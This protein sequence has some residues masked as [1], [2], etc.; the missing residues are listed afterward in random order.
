LHPEIA[1]WK[2]TVLQ[3]LKDDSLGVG[4]ASEGGGLPGSA[5]GTLAVLLVGPALEATVGGELAGSVKTAWLVV[6]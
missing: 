2:R 4:G 6:T 5:E 3:L 1:H